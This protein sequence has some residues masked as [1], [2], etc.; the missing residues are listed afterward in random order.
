M[1]EQKELIKNKESG[2]AK[3]AGVKGDILSSV[4]EN[5]SVNH[6]G[7]LNVSKT[8]VIKERMPSK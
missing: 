2:E 5:K 6:G 4:V 7:S 8:T 1:K 3:V